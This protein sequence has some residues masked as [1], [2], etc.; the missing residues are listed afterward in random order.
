MDILTFGIDVALSAAAFGV[1]RFI[2]GKS[3]R[4]QP[5]VDDK[6]RCTGYRFG[7]GAVNI[8]KDDCTALRSALCEDG[9][10]TY[11]CGQMCKCQGIFK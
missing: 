10:C 5:D 6:P 7:H 8:M 1:G 2:A 3:A 9:R 11:H 4:R